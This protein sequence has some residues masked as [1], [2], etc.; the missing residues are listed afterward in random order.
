MDSLTQKLM[1]GCSAAALFSVLVPSAKAQQAQPTE[2]VE[3]VTV[4]GSRITIPGYTAPT[5]V[6]DGKEVFVA[7]GNG[8]VACYD[9]DGNRKWLKLI[10]HSNAAF[11][12]SGSPLLVG[13]K[14]LMSEFMGA[15]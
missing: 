3:Q 14:L 7:F 13:D 12:H 6:T 11:A 4:S 8:L 15:H 10:E 1:L 5:P 2:N 9:L